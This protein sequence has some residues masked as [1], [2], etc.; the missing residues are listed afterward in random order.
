MTD[1]P[2]VQPSGLNFDGLAGKLGKRPS[3]PASP[4]AGPDTAGPD[5]A[6]SA[7]PVPPEPRDSARPAGPVGE[8]R[9]QRAKTAPDRR[10]E[11]RRL[12]FTLPIDLRDAFTAAAAQDSTQAEV[13]FDAIEGALDELPGLLRDDRDDDPAGLFQRRHRAQPAPRVTLSVWMSTDNLTAIDRLTAQHKA[14]SRT[15]LIEVALRRHLLSRPA[16]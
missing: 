2:R 14:S 9:S 12:A 16:A 7:E 15:R 5:P 3:P 6:R 10:L 1:T 13:I 4:P 8:R 11:R